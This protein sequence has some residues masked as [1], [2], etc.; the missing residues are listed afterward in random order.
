MYLSEPAIDQ[1][2]RAVRALG[3]SAPST[4]VFNYFERDAV[5]RG[6]HAMR[7]A[8]AVMGEP[9][10]FGW[11]PSELR[12]WLAARGFALR[13]DRSDVELSRALLPRV[14][15]PRSRGSHVVIA[16]SAPNAAG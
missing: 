11:R 16:A 3:R 13:S 2:V 5:E 10:K 6:N 7:V 14:T 12:S 9:F 8:V 4:L 15:R 1:T